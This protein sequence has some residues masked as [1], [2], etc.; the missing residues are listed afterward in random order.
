MAER[1]TGDTWLPTGARSGRSRSIFW[2]G[3]GAP[4][5]TY[6]GDLHNH[7][8]V[9]YA[10]GSLGRSFEIARNHLEFF[11]FTPHAHWPDIGSYENNIE[12][13]WLDGFKVT[14][15]S[16]PEVRE[17]ARKFDAPGRFVPILGYEWHSTSLGDYHLLFPTLDAEL[18]PFDDLR[19]MQQFAR[20]QGAIL[21]PHHPAN[22]LG[23][24]GANFARR[25]PAVSPLVEIYSEWGNAEHD[26][27]PFPYTRHT[28]G[29]RWT[30]NTVP[31]MLAQ[32]HRVGFVASTDDHL[33]YPGAYREGLAAVRATD[34]SRAAIFDALRNRRTY[35][36][37]GDR[38]DLDF[39]L[40]G[41]LMGS[42]LP[43]ARRRQLAISVTGW[44]EIDRVEVL[45]NNVVIHR[46]HPV[47]RIASTRRWAEPVLIRAGAL[48]RPWG[49]AAFATGT[50][51]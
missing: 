38:I 50:S 7:S 49:W 4:Y 21:V 41:H 30:K 10:R 12:K 25:D 22:R 17:M 43:Y 11:A 37:T 27:A 8:A 3:G 1:G 15:R 24:R 31:R 20:E 36:V 47:D 14:A 32:G 46:D 6:W 44:D 34:L 29:G 19:A 40:N 9:G 26:R 18:K 2:E 45:K 33:G 42:E 39:T 5:K 23:H 13:K 48:G 16:W 51:G 35:A 28:E